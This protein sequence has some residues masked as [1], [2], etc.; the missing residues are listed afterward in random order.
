[1]EMLSGLVV[2]V[3]GPILDVRFNGRLPAILDAV[4]IERPGKAQIGRASCRERV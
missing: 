3:A 2:R 4:E 1:M